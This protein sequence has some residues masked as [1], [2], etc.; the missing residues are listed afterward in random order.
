MVEEEIAIIDTV[1]NRKN[2]DE[3]SNAREKEMS[4]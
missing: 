3:T 4:V 1:E 2:K